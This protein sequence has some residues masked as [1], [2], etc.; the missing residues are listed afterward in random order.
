[1]SARRTLLH[2]A[3]KTGMLVGAIF[4]VTVLLVATPG[5]RAPAAQS[6]AA[7]RPARRIPPRKN[8]ASRKP[9]PCPAWT[10]AMKKPAKRPP[11]RT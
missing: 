10:W 2:L 6:P 11:S 4:V 9:H 1:M 7:T 3:A 5:H 8:P